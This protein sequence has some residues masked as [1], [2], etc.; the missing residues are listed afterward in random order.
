MHSLNLAAF[1][2]P[3][4]DAFIVTAA[5]SYKSKGVGFRVSHVMPKLL[6]AL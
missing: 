5:R 1:P 4:A 3:S 6:V 2:L